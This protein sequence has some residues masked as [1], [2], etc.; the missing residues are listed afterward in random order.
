M[1]NLNLAP[2]LAAAFDI[3][4]DGNT[5][6]IGG[7][8]RYYANRLLTYKLRE[9]TPGSYSEQWSVTNGWILKSTGSTAYSFSQL[10]T[11]YADEYVIG[12]EQQLFGGSASLKYVRRNGRN[13][14]A[15]TMTDRQADGKFYYI[16]N[17]N[18]RSRHESYRISWERQWRRHYLNVNGTY[19]ET[20]SSNESYD[21]LLNDEDLDEEVWYNG[22]AI[23]KSQLPRNDF[24]RPWL[25]NVLY[26]GQLPY[27]I[28]FSS[29]LKYR[30]GY[31]ALQKTGET[32][33]DLGIPIYEET[34]LGGAATIDCKIDWR[35]RIWTRQELVLSLEILNLL[36]KKS[37][38]G[39]EEDT[40]E[41]GRQFWLGA[42]YLF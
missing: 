20:D 30:S 18:G 9:G 21:D 13:E 23:L 8:N 32:H 14:F 35:T 42:K 6:F 15:K 10:D 39:E 16:L 2:R 29:L 4:G 38:S 1:S 37:A 17:N 22:Q 12:L 11:P 41:M 25:I 19:Q 27:N 34:K 31:H 26:V 3:F 33:A 7:I 24:N 5:V 36:N 40:Y 28:T